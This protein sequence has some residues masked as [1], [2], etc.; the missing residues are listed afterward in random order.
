M[1]INLHIDTHGRKNS[2]VI[3]GFIQPVARLLR[4]GDHF[5]HD[6]TLTQVDA[7]FTR[8]THAQSNYYFKL[9]CVKRVYVH[10]RTSTIIIISVLYIAV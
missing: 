9:I 2:F 3:T 8:L 7:K 4:R 1:H 6:W 10:A 5:S